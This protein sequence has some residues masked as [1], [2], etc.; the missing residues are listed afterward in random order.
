MI[1][2]MTITEVMPELKAICK[3]YGLKINR[4]KD[5]NVAKKLL[6]IRF[7]YYGKYQA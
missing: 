7:S 4:V 3:E 1:G 2:K 5:F 6:A